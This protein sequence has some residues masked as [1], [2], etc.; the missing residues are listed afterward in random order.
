L[1]LQAVYDWWN[2]CRLTDKETREKKTHG[3]EKE[4]E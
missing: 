3:E 4:K 2:P 1:V